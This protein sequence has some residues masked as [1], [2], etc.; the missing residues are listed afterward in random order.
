MRG[1]L[2][3]FVDR[4]LPVIPVLLPGA[5]EVPR[6]PIFL[7]GFTWVDLRGGLTE[8]GI[9]RLQWGITGKRPDRPNSTPE[10]GAA[11]KTALDQS[12]PKS[13]E[14]SAVPEIE[15][16]A[17]VAQDQ[18]S[19]TTR[20]RE[21]W[22]LEAKSVSLWPL[23]ETKHFLAKLNRRRAALSLITISTLLLF[24][25]EKEGPS[26]TPRRIVQ[27]KGNFA[28][29]FS[30]LVALVPRN[31]PPG[32]NHMTALLLAAR[33]DP[34]T[35][36]ECLSPYRASIRL[37][38]SAAECIDAGCLFSG[39]STCTCELDRQEVSIGPDVEPPKQLLRRSPSSILPNK[40]S[41]GDFSYFAN[42]AQSPF[43]QTL[44]PQY[45]GPT[46]PPNL[47]ARMTFPFESITACVMST[48]VN[49]APD[50]ILP[51]GFGWHAKKD[52]MVQAVAQAAVAMFK[53]AYSVT[54]VTIS[55]FD[56]NKPHHLKARSGILLENAPEFLP[57]EDTCAKDVSQDFA[58]FYNLALNPPPWKDRLIPRLR[59]ALGSAENFKIPQC[60]P[61]N[62]SIVGFPISPMASF[63]P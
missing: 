45:L 16:P 40:E 52:L 53:P 6:L 17:A 2:S 21:S 38:T 37:E 31:D 20:T 48:S 15:K 1:C 24:I 13:V 61:F 55:N 56:G 58:F 5:P 59:Y 9:D 44:N 54:T 39:P 29:A 7:K 33:P 62:H 41:A 14:V 27:G 8:G 4:N 25:A 10:A 43:E 51:M 30:G 49:E 47:V 63:N 46:P 32:A 35:K 3:E 12:Q 50:R 57:P 60:S 28:I 23:A 11:S 18:P 19:K 42:L 36:V 26:I 34:A 22:L